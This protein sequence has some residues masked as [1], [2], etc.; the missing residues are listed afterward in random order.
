MRLS[1]QIDFV[2]RTYNLTTLLVLQVDVDQG[3]LDAF[4]AQEFFDGENVYAIFKQVSGKT[5]PEAVNRSW[6]CD[7]G[8]FLAL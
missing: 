2:Q 4:V 1:S 3:R 8:F 5:V 6:F 7:A